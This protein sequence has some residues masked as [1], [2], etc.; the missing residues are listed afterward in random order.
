MNTPVNKIAKNMFFTASQWYSA[1]NY[2]T[3]L[4]IVKIGTQLFVIGYYA[5]VICQNIISRNLS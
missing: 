3:S 4:Q 5:R 2:I 1:A